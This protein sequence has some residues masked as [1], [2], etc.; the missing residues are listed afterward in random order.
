MTWPDDDFEKIGD[1]DESK[2][3]TIEVPVIDINH[4]TIEPTEEQGNYFTLTVI[5]GNDF[6]TVF[7]LEKT[8]TILGRSPDNDIPINDEKASRN[9]LKII[10]EQSDFLEKISR[11]MAEDLQ[12]KNGTFVNGER[13]DEIELRNLDKLQIGDTILKFEMKDYLDF[14]YH[15][16]LYKQATHDALTGLRNRNHIQESMDRLLSISNR[17]GRPFSILLMDIDNFKSI[18]DSYGHNI[19]DIVLR[20]VSQVFLMQLR[21][22]DIAARYGGEEFLILMPETPIEGALAAAERLRYAVENSDFSL[23][24]CERKVTISI[25]VTQYP[26]CGNNNDTLIKEADEALYNAKQTGRNRVCA[27]KSVNLLTEK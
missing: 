3:K 6:G 22:H 5:E 10:K 15:E 16:R 7:L 2:D 21:S 25:G 19:G 1:D 8:E 26:L 4:L 9:H 23:L 24:G 12:S 11:V 17:H 20:T 13:I 14:H 27:G 18:N